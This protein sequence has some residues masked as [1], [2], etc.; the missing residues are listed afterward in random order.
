MKNIKSHKSYGVSYLGAIFIYRELVVEVSEFLVLLR[1]R[2][3]VL[4]GSQLLLFDT[5]T[6][7][8]A[9]TAS[10]QGRLGRCSS[11]EVAEWTL[12]CR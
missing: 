7:A 10:R 9:L 11:V 8:G 1:V 3:S 5:A 12:T 4:L 2:L 6:A